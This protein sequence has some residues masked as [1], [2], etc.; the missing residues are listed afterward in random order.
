MF[1]K[2]KAE[3][4]ATTSVFS[5]VFLISFPFSSAVHFVVVCLFSLLVYPLSSPPSPCSFCSSSFSS[6]SSYVI[7]LFVGIIKGSARPPDSRDAESIM[8]FKF[9]FGG[10][11]RCSFRHECYIAWMF[12]FLDYLLLWFFFLLQ[13]YQQAK[14]F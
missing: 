10:R 5:A 12:D 8:V 11:F 3:N 14:M 4:Q 7:S 6:P 1:R 9:S 2:W 13:V